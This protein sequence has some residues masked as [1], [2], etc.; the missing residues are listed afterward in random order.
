[1]LC[2]QNLLKFHGCHSLF[3]VSFATGCNTTPKTDRSIL[4]IKSW[5]CVFFHEM[6]TFSP[7]IPLFIHQSTATISRTSQSSV[8]V[9]FCTFGVGFYDEDTGKVPITDSSMSLCKYSCTVWHC[10]AKANDGF[11]LTDQ[12]TSS[13]PLNLLIIFCTVETAS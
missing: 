11:D 3:N 7:S 9:P 8:A 6:L 10:H 2:L 4:M 12:F 13:S 5:K 1:M